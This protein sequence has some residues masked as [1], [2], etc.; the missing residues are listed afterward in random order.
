M[1]RL[2]AIDSRS[3]LRGYG[4]LTFFAGVL[5][6]AFPWPATRYF[7]TAHIDRVA[8]W[9]FIKMMMALVIWASG[10][11]AGHAARI[12][13]PVDRRKALTTL[14]GAVLFA[15][16]FYFAPAWPQ[17]RV[18]PFGLFAPAIASG[19]VLL[20]L[21]Y[22]SLGPRGQLVRMQGSMVL[23]DQPSPKGRYEE[24][25]RQAARQEERG[26]LARDLHDAVKQQLFV[27]QTAAATVE[28]RLDADRQGASTALAQVR[29]SAREALTEMEVMLE[30]LQAAPLGNAGSV[31]VVET[32]LAAMLMGCVVAW[33]NARPW[34]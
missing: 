17:M 28:Q 31:A 26:R 6:V 34:A 9:Q 29:A 12:E 8:A 13:D 1:L 30:Q 7:A 19:F 11:F 32:A 18:L 3:V 20:C 14:A 24:S 27:I 4:V 33:R 5:L 10:A 16:L 23:R 21:S 22:L 2:L 15:G 25:I